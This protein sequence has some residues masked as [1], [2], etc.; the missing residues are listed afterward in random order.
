M[1]GHAIT[2]T[3]DQWPQKLISSSLSQDKLRSKQLG[4]NL[5][6]DHHGSD[7]PDGRTDRRHEN[8]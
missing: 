5:S 7:I 2:M 8:I 3:F 1:H 6:I 4:K